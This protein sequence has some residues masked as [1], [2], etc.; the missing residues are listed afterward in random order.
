M[1][2]FPTVGDF[3]SIYTRTICFFIQN[4]FLF[5]Q[6]SPDNRKEPF[7]TISCQFKVKQ[8]KLRFVN[9]GKTISINNVFTQHKTILIFRAYFIYFFPPQNFNLQQWLVYAAAYQSFPKKK[10]TDKNQRNYIAALLY[11]Q[12]KKYINLMNE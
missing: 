8:G 5:L 2:S 3:I 12:Q 1:F 4:H 11:E 10:K 9:V 7:I 6:N